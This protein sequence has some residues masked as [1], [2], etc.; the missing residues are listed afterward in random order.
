MQ[1]D[2]GLIFKV[3]VVVVVD[4]LMKLRLPLFHYYYINIE[5]I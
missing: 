1:S 4:T 5:V 3:V 2:L